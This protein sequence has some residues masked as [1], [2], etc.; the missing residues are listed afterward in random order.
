MDRERREKAEGYF[1][2]DGF[3]PIE[4]DRPGQDS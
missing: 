2:S 4:G 1:R 3:V